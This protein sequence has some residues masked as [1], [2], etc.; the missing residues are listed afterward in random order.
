MEMMAMSEMPEEQ[1][2]DQGGTPPDQGTNVDGDGDPPEGQADP[3]AE[4]P[5]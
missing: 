3:P 2:V 5:D 1:Q 4:A